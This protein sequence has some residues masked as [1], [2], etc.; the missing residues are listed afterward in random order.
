MRAVANCSSTHSGQFVDH[1]PKWSPAPQPDRQQSAGDAI[2]LC[3]RTRPTSGG[4]PLGG[5]RSRRGRRTAAPSRRSTAPMVSPSTHGSGCRIGG[6]WKKRASRRRQTSLKSSSGNA[7]RSQAN[8]SLRPRRSPSST[9]DRIAGNGRPC[10]PRKAPAQ[11]RRPARASAAHV[12][13]DRGVAPEGSAFAAER[14]FHPA[15]RQRTAPHLRPIDP[16]ARQ[17]RE[18]RSPLPAARRP[19]G[20]SAASATP[21]PIPPIPAS[22]VPPQA[23]SSPNVISGRPSRVE[24]SSRAIR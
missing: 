19:F 16:E 20:R 17:R 3:D 2:D 15:A 13:F 18:V 6:R 11:L 14:V 4:R 21:L 24:S 10:R 12:R 9:A 8:P 22:C 1:T 7:S 5:R 23:G